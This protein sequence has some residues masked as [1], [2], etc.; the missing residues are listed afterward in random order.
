MLLFEGAPQTATKQAVISECGEYRYSL[1]RAWNDGLPCLLYVC[2]N[3]SD[4]D[5]QRD[6]PTIRRCVAFAR[7][8]GFGSIE[9]VNLFAV[10]SPDPAYMMGHPCPVGPFN[11]R[12][13]IE[14]V[15]RAARVVVAWGAHGGH[16]GRDREVMKLVR[17]YFNTVY[18]FGLSKDGMPIHPAA[19]GKSRIPDDVTLIEYIG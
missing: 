7:R 3:P 5:H 1:T 9:V 6:D 15:R 4:A 19:R 10:R 11:D 8:W 14:A 18:C 12:H 13:I 17:Q 2:L 16:M